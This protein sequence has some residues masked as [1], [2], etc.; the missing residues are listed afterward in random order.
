[1]S[2]QNAFPGPNTG[3]PVARPTNPER[4]RQPSWVHPQA[5]AAQ[6]P[7]QANGW[8]QQP[9][10][11]QQGGFAQQGYGAPTP[12][13]QTDYGHWGEFADRRPCRS[14]GSRGPCG[15]VRAA[16]RTVRSDTPGLWPSAGRPRLR[17]PAI[18][19]V[20]SARY[21]SAQRPTRLRG[22]RSDCARS[23]RPAGHAAV[24]SWR[25]VIRTALSGTGPRSR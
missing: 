14:A 15:P 3:R 12:N 4:P 17:R 10:Q 9:A 7:Q 25:G 5:Q 23:R 19:S 16:I 13:A 18:A 1:M 11:P 24:C 8:Q 2:S 21:R 20:V 6:P 22:R